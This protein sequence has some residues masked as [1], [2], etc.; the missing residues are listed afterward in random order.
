LCNFA[1]KQEMTTAKEITE[2]ANIIR[3]GGLVV[4]PTETVYGL[5]ANALDAYAVSKIF[6]EKER[7]FFDPLIVHVAAFEDVEKL[8]TERRPELKTLMRAFWPGPLTIVVEKNQLVPDIVTAG[9][10]TVGIR[11]PNNPIALALIREAAC[12]I[13][14]P[15]ANKFGRTSPTSLLH[16][17]KQ[18]SSEPYYLDGGKTTVGIESTVITLRDDGFLIL[19]PGY[20]TAE[21]ISVYMPKSKQV[22]VSKTEAPGMLESHYSPRKPLYVLGQH[23]IPQNIAQAGLLAFGDSCHHGFLSTQNLSPSGDLKEAAVN[24]FGY[25]HTMDESDVAFIVVEPIP[26][27]GVGIAVMD[28]IRKAS[29]K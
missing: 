2:A 25:M 10:S 7:P 18:L 14:A 17:K 27:I 4:F 5:G 13:A 3:Q 8:T 21:D 1:K 6:E 29:V 15:S 26:E 23:S 12:P 19:R 20:I 9:L 22:A 24:L 28:R 11:M 16:A